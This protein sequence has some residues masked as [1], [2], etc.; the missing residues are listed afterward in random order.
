M[1]T[2]A[3]FVAL[4]GA[5]YA[6]TQLPS[7]SVGTRQIKKGAVTPVKLSQGS[8]SALT[9]PAGPTGPTGPAGAAGTPGTPGPQG[10]KG[11]KGELGERGEKGDR[12][13]EGPSD[14][15]LDATF[16]GGPLSETSAD[17]GELNVPAGSYLVSATA[18][19]IST[20]AGGSNAQCLIVNLS[21]GNGSQ[22]N[23]NL[24]GTNDRKVLPLIFTQTVE[25]PSTFAIRCETTSG[26]SSVSVD[27]M[28]LVAVKVGTLH[29]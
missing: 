24:S 19:L 12:G 23:V 29:E 6:A 16:P 7:N 28:N 3:L 21:G 13:P 25:A 14:A 10:E 15:Y 1:A 17:F 20:G 26:G 22:M 4:G 11:E 9:G 27:E 18:R 2:L 5:G 8:K